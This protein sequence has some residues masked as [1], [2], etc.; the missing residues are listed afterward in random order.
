MRIQDLFDPSLLEQMIAEKYVRTRADEE[1]PITV[2]DYTERAQFKRVWN[3]VTLTCRGLL[4]HSHSGEIV[5]RSLPKF[6]NYAE[7]G[8]AHIGSGPVEV[9]DK[10]DGSLGILYPV[11]GHPGE[12]RISTRGSLRSK[13]A[14]TGSE[15]WQSRYADGFAPN[16]AWT[17]LFEIIAPITRVVVDY[18][19][20]R[21]L[22]LLGAVETHTGRTVPFDQAR[23]GWP[24]PVVTR[25]EYTTLTEALAADPRPNAEGFVVLDP[26]T[27]HR[28]KIKQEDYKRLHGL[29][30]GLRM[31]DLWA[32]L[33]VED[34][35]E[36]PIGVAVKRLKLDG[37]KIESLRKSLDDGLDDMLARVPDELYEHV[38]ATMAQMR[39]EHTAR[40]E[41]IVSSFHALGLDEIEDRKG[42]AM[43]IQA[44]A[45]DKFTKHMWLA[46]LNG[47]DI[48]APLWVDMQPDPHTMVLDT[49]AEV[50]FVPF[51]TS[52]DSGTSAQTA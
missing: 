6:F 9:Y 31:I 19:A 16:P 15:I 48:A 47:G 35:R 11:P 52:G 23:E 51:A 46:L 38:K 28:V 37:T 1:Y 8:A 14:E 17:Y 45:P 4:V 41:E 33:A 43:R 30:T 27:G 18:G 2:Y 12:Y 5:A 24:G 22:V 50:G 3:E 36:V 42:K 34:T 26:A 13:Q 49:T 7:T 25:F 29:I 40:T 39:A 20:T 21:D 10:V 32:L 44:A